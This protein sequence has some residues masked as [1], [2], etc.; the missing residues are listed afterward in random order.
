MPRERPELTL[1]DIPQIKRKKPL[2]QMYDWAALLGFS[3]LENEHAEELSHVIALAEAGPR[4]VAGLGRKRTAAT[5]K[6]FAKKLRR[7]QL[8]GRPNLDVRRLFAEERLGLDTDTFLRLAPLAGAPGSQLLAAIETRHGEL[9]R[10]PRRSP[11]RDAL[12]SAGGAAVLFFLVRA[13]DNV[14]DEPGAW[15]KF[16]LAVLA[17]AGFPTEKLHQHPESLRPL[18][19]RL[20]VEAEPLT[21]TVRSAP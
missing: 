3:R 14:R 15:W 5:L 9:E 7:E 6:R 11:Q 10:L 12:E 20:R 4:V 21:G 1:I 13:G 2:S 19:E 16:V 18:L 8:T 17:A